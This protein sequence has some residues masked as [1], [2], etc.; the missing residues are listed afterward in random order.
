MDVGKLPKDGRVTTTLGTGS[1]VHAVGILIPEDFKTVIH[2][3]KE[4]K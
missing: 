2:T 1:I 3:E 4:G